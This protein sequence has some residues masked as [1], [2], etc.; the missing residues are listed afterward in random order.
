M[1]E[2]NGNK[3]EEYNKEEPNKEI[4]LI[5]KI[6]IDEELLIFSKKSVC[7]EVSNTKIVWKEDRVEEIL[8]LAQI[9]SCRRQIRRA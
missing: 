4:R 6:V 7:E 9:Q 3:E 8:Q 1:E 2:Q 5:Q